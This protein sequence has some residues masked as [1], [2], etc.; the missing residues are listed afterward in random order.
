MNTL[1]YDAMTVGNHEFDD[2]PQ[3]LREFIDSVDFPVLMSNVDTS[4][5]PALAN[6]IM[7]ST[8]WKEVEKNTA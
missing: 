2:G 5:E 6:K 3:V 4:K 1:E 7:K 8:V